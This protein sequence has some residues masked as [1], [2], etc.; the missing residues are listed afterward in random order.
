MT[1]APFIVVLGVGN[2]MM[3]DDGIGVRAVRTL[4]E[5]YELP[6]RVRLVEGGVAGLRCLSEFE[7]AG[8]ILIVDAADGK[9]PPG[10][11]AR[12]SP[13]ELPERREGVFSAHEM[14]VADL[15]SIARF[16]G[17]LPPTRIVAVQP[18]EAHSVG[19]DL[20]PELL[21]ALP[22]VV[23]VLAEELRALGVEPVRKGARHA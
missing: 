15:L 22:R 13:E 2:T 3:Q 14:G 1:G 18:K 21:D 8:N 20:T 4:A 16:L 10:A 17:K 6:P 23:E 9:K 19:P 11:I 5:T 12:L 7:G